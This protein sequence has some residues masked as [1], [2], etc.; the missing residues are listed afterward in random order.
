M[1]RRSSTTIQ[2][3]GVM[4]RLIRTILFLSIADKSR[5]S[6][7]LLDM[8]VKAERMGWLPSSPQFN[9]NPLHVA[10]KAKAEGLSSGRLHGEKLKRWQHQVCRRT[11]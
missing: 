6:E 2:A 11:T 5:Y 8:N 10:E 9:I 4:K 3:N 7:S 1:V